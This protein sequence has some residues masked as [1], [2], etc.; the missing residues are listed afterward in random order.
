[1]VAEDI[2]EYV[3]DRSAALLASPAIVTAG[4]SAI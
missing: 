2:S 1:M 3:G 4:I